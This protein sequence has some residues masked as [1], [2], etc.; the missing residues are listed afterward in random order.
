[1]K[2]T[3]P[4]PVSFSFLGVRPPSRGSGV[5]RFVHSFVQECT[6]PPD[7]GCPWHSGMSSW[8]R[9]RLCRRSTSYL[10]RYKVPP[11]SYEVH[12]STPAVSLADSVKV[13]RYTCEYTSLSSR[14]FEQVPLQVPGTQPIISPFL[15]F[16]A[17]TLPEVVASMLPSLPRSRQVPGTAK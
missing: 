7:A 2:H 12:P 5:V 15:F 14:Y 11:G 10:V 8:V 4:G 1:M 16:R 3:S 13:P 9:C 6:S 17:V